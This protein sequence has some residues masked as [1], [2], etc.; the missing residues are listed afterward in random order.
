MLC[1]TLR[2][3]L[4]TMALGS[5][6]LAIVSALRLLLE[7]VDQQTKDTQDANPVVS[8]GMK[9]CNCCMVTPHPHPST[10]ILVCQITRWLPRIHL[11]GQAPETAVSFASSHW[12]VSWMCSGASRSRLNLYPS[13]RLCMLSWT[14]ARFALLACPLSGSSQS[15]LH[16]WPSTLLYALPAAYARAVVDVQ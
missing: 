14:T 11:R 15:I 16:S 13:T 3:N 6:V 4:G 5:F 2:F 12:R 7:V 1:H 9:C 10:P 8:M